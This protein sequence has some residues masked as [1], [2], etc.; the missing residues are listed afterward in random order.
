MPDYHLKD[1]RQGIIGPIRLETVRDLIDAG[2]IE[3]D[4]LVSKDGGAFVPLASLAELSA[5]LPPTSGQITIMRASQLKTAQ[6]IAKAIRG[7][8]IVL[9]TIALLLFALALW[10]AH[11]RRRSTLRS[12]RC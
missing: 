11:G 6:D 1:P 12:K 7:L 10:L 9:P 3:G 5:T 2:V 4:V 8:A